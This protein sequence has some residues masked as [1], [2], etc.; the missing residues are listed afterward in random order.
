VSTNYLF[1][2][3]AINAQDDWTINSKDYGFNM[4]FRVNFEKG[5]LV[6]E[7][8]KLTAYPVDAPAYEPEMNKDDG[9][10]REICYFIDAIINDK[11]IETASPCSTKESIRL[12]L[13]EMKSADM[14]GACVA[15]D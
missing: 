3:M 5:A 1:P 4:L 6:F 14:G 8:G 9:Y 2:G 10:Y 13:A 15:L 7:N 11:P 12:A